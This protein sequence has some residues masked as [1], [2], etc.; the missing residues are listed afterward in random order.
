MRR[1]IILI[2]LL[3]LGALLSSCTMQIDRMRRDHPK[4]GDEHLYALIQWG[5]QGAFESAA[6]T[7]AAMNN[8]NSFAVFMQTMGVAFA[9]WTAASIQKAKEISAQVMAGEMTKQQA[10]QQLHA[11]QMY[12]AGLKAA[13][14]GQAIGAGAVVNPITL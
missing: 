11:L 14:K 2:P 8:E 7:R 13:T 6:G 10:Q 1:L 12:E 5:G 3:L 4:V 9:G